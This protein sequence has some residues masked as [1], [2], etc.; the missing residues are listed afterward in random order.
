MGF[1]FKRID[2]VGGSA[3]FPTGDSDSLRRSRSETVLTKCVQAILDCNVGWALDISK[4]ATIT[5][6]VDIPNVDNTMF[7]GLF[8]TNNTSGC[9][10]FIAYLAC[11]N[12]VGI[13]DFS[14][15]GSDILQLNNNTNRY[16]SGLC[17]SMIPEG[18]SSTFGDPTTTTF[19]PSDAT[20]IIGSVNC[21]YNKNDYGSFAYK[22][23][24]GYTWSWGLF[25][26]PYTIALSTAYINGSNPNFGTPSYAVGRILGTLIHT[27]DNTNQSRY[28]VLTLKRW[29]D[30]AYEGDMP[31]VNFGAGAFSSPTKYFI[32]SDPNATANIS[33]LAIAEK[34]CACIARADGTWVGG[35]NGTNTVVVIYPDNIGQISPNV[36]SN[37]GKSRWSPF[38]VCVVSSDLSTDG[39]VSG[40]GFKGYLDTDLF[41]SAIGLYC[42]EFDNGNFICVD[43]TNNFLIGWDPSNTDLLSGT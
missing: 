8:L 37:I 21:Y 11:K 39:V 15:T 30:V 31:V 28:G 42:Q 38:T 36:Y 35:T 16:S 7:P 27:L 25:V 4:N 13:K 18:S 41:R 32:G 20:R 43:S 26:N 1:K 33:G 22:P 3:E 12:I 5:S 9:K 17:M 29:T 2:L 6:F 34:A 19:L 14:G 23:T 40:D 24:A 10:L